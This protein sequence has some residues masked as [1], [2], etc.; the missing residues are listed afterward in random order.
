VIK[1]CKYKEG[2]KCTGACLVAEK[3][4]NFSTVRWDSTTGSTVLGAGF[5]F[6][7]YFF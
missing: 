7:H 6:K 2:G 1:F 5:F 3:I 4:Q